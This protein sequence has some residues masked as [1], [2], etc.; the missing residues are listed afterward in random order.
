MDLLPNNK[1]DLKVS[2][3]ITQKQVSTLI[4]SN[5]EIDVPYLS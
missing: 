1:I 5:L 3:K 2:Q 4:K